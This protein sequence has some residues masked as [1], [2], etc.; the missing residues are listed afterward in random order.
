MN[1]LRILK[2]DYDLS[3][4]FSKHPLTQIYIYILNIKTQKIFRL[5]QSHDY[6]YLGK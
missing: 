5:T 4:P 3:L 2:I 6:Q 1:I